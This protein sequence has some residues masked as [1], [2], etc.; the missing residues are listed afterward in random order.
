MDI[1]INIFIIH[2][3]IFIVTLFSMNAA[4]SAVT[5]GGWLAACRAGIDCDDLSGGARLLATVRASSPLSLS[6]TIITPS[7]VTTCSQLLPVT[8]DT[9]P[10]T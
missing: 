1:F 2:A 8:G 9:S 6:P 5:V 7:L 10:H 3:F 4:T